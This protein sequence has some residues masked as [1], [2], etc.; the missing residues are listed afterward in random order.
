MIVMPAD[1]VIFIGIRLFL[2]RII[3]NEYAIFSLYLTHVGFDE[4]PPFFRGLLLSRQHA[5]DLIM[6]DSAIHQI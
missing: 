4:Q 3:N 1:D 5:S 2:N 6:T